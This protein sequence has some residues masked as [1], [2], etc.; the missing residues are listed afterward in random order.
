MRID[1]HS[2]FLLGLMEDALSG[3]VMPA[4]MQRPYVWSKQDVEA[5]CDSIISRFPIGGFLFWQPPRGTPINMVSKGRLGPV[6]CKKIP[7]NDSPL[8]LLDGQNRITTI[9]WMALQGP[10]PL[11]DELSTCEKVTWATGSTLVL[12]GDTKTMH[13][14][15]EEEASIGL[16]LPAWTVIDTCKVRNKINA[17]AYI[18]SQYSKWISKHSEQEINAFEELFD[19]VSNSFRNARITSTVILDATPEEARNA[20]LRICKVG[21]PMS[22]QDFD[23]AINWISPTSKPKQAKPS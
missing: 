9:A 8:L 22:E 16:K 15:T 10:S 13:F 2:S 11:F 5:L 23:M 19:E 18:R 4:V 6:T 12:D 3:R 1:Q 7:S 20:F 17:N 14:V 21:V